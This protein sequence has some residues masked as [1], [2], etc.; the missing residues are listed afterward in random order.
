[1]VVWATAREA[2]ARMIAAAKRILVYWSS[3][4]EK[5]GME[6]YVLDG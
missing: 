6:R 5:V 3:L 1:V 4:R 2:E